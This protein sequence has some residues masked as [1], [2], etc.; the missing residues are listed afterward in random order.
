MAW[1]TAGRGRT[2]VPTGIA[3][4][5]VR[6]VAL[7]GGGYPSR[8]SGPAAGSSVV[9]VRAGSRARRPASPITVRPDCVWLTFRGDPERPRRRLTGRSRCDAAR[10]MAP[11]RRLAT[12][13]ADPPTV[14]SY[15]CAGRPR[16]PRCPAARAGLEDDPLKPPID[17][18]R[19]ASPSL[20][21]PSP[22]FATGPWPCCWRTGWQSGCGRPASMARPPAA[23]RARAATTP[24]G[25][26]GCPRA[27][28]GPLS[29][30]TG[31]GRPGC[32]ST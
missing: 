26:A 32:E 27:V 18:G 2:S 8:P 3:V 17:G 5:T 14:L 13:G 25:A 29:P 10:E 12:A 19:A 7:P 30:G 21:R 23:C 24:S 11:P 15:C 16:R 9:T 22:A 6:A 1:P 31:G 4:A 28:R 20:G